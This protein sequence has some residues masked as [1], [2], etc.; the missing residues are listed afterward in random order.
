MY[1]RLGF[2]FLIMSVVLVSCVSNDKKQGAQNL[3]A[4]YSISGEEGKEFVT[5]FLQFSDGSEDFAS[6]LK[7]PAQVFLDDILLTADSARESGAFYELQVPVEEFAGTHVIR[8]VDEAGAEYKEEF[9][10]EPFRLNTQLEEVMTRQNLI[11]D[12]EGVEDKEMLRVVIIDTSFG[13]DGVNELD[14]IVN[15]QLD[16]R[17]FLPDLSNGPIVLHLFKEEDRKITTG[18]KGK[19]SITYGLKREFELKD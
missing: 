11:L 8:Y 6:V 3:Y 12:L 7:H 2:L 14:T 1:K 18:Q 5:V 13:S 9:S 15:R 19:I 17:E 16:L 10:F 4:N